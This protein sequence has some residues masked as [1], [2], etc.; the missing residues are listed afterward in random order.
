[1]TGPTTRTGWLDIR[2]WTS[3][4]CHDADKPYRIPQ[5]ISPR[6]H[7]IVFRCAAIAS[8]LAVLG[9]SVPSAAVTSP[10]GATPG[11]FA[12]S[13]S[14]AATYSIPIFVPPGTNG[15]QPQL[16]LSYNSQGGNG[17]VGMG[18]SIGGLSVIHRCGA[19]IATDGF[20]GGVNYDTN[21]K[22]C[23]DGERLIW[24]EAPPFPRTVI[25]KPYPYA[26]L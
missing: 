5:L 15:M 7:L 3:G 19:T 16:S 12:V 13:P 8:L 14:G 25:V 21:D 6:L 4:V 17:L 10:V 9:F 18:W 1:M 11:A 20:K 23:L 26:L 24:V 2:L 22:F